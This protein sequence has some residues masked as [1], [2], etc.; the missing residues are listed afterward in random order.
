LSYT[1]SRYEDG[2]VE[3]TQDGVSLTFTASEARDVAEQLRSPSVRAY[4]VE[5]RVAPRPVEPIEDW[6][7]INLIA[8]RRQVETDLARSR[9][10]QSEQRRQRREAAIR[11]LLLG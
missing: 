9:L 1:L 3:I 8:E 11:R 2:S 10:D 6:Q 5:K 7:A 4:V